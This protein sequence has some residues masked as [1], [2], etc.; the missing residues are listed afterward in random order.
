MAVSGM[1]KSGGASVG[2]KRKAC[3]GADSGVGKKQYKGANSKAKKEEKPVILDRKGR[4][5]LRKN[6][7]QLKNHSDTLDR[8]KQI[9]EIVRNKG[10]C[11]KEKRTPLIEELVGLTKGKVC[12]IIFKHDAAR[13]I[14]CCI[15]FGTVE[16]R[17]QI[18]EEL[19]DNIVDLMKQKYSKFIITK[20]LK[21]GNKEQRQQIISAMFGHVRKLV[22]HREACLIV[23]TVYNDYANAQQRLSLVQEFYGPQF[24]LFKTKDTKGLEEIFAANPDKKAGIVKYLKGSLI[25]CMDKGTIGNSIVHKGLL[26]CLHVCDDNDKKELVD[27]LKELLVEILHT[28]DGAQVA[29]ECL[30]AASPKER[31]AIIKSF[32]P[33]FKKI[34]MEEFG[35][36][37]MVTAFECV[38]DTVMMKKVLLPELVG[39][40]D[41]LFVDKYGRKVLLS[42][43]SPRSKQYFFPATVELLQMGDSNSFSKKSAEQRRRENLNTIRKPLLEYITKNCEEALCVGL[44][45]QLVAETM[46]NCGREVYDEAFKDAVKCVSSLASRGMKKAAADEEAERPAEALR[47]CVMTHAIAHRALRRMAEEQLF[48]EGEC[49]IA[50][51]LVEALTPYLEEALE[52]N[53]ASFVLV[54]ILKSKDAEA[55]KALKAQL[56]SKALQSILSSQTHPAS[57][58]ILE[59]L[60]A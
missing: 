47:T 8:M 6:R 28:K 49:S 30:W 51:S 7:R 40:L 3:D 15:Q 5:E 52:N 13:V 48:K 60:D 32:K 10:E 36:L 11:S 31:K 55:A 20:M 59:L 54:G 45:S 37:A 44:P 29:V 16:H 4:E 14:Q 34:C 43:L 22:R 46:I 53:F 21:C 18:L 24:A 9:W 23:E 1:K 27:S 58:V 33:F 12:E 38:D 39:S 42:I 56:N 50:H 17:S 26:D 41:E 35:H 19:K 2:H 57:K 25:P